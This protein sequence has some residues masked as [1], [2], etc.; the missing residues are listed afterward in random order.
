MTKSLNVS[1]K[2][3]RNCSISSIILIYIFIYLYKVHRKTLYKPTL[4]LTILI[5]SSPMCVGAAMAVVD[6][7]NYYR[8]L[9][10]NNFII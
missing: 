1:L 6:Y 3:V 10:I 9:D 7:I 2:L 5:R 8:C 4:M